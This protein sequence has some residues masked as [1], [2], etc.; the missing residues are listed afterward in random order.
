MV[1][2]IEISWIVAVFL[3]S[4]RLG[5][6]LLVTPILDGFAVPV[7]IKVFLIMAL[8]VFLV[9]CLRLSTGT[10]PLTVG[11][12]LAAG[13]TELVNGALLAFGVFTAFG[14]V[15]FAGKTLDIQMGF[16]VANVF[17][18]VTRSQSPL[19]G[20]ALGTLAVVMFFLTDAHHALMRGVAYSLTQV[21]LGGIV[22]NASPESIVRQFGTTFTL[23]LLFA[24][25]VVFCLFLLEI[26]LAVLSRNLPQ[27]NI[28]VISIPVKIVA[29]FLA[30]GF[31]SRHLES[32]FNKIFGSIFTFWDM[33]L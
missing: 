31:L 1:F 2:E 10:M 12:L 23:G 4:I 25:P 21:P 15:A 18:P 19:L 22:A 14:A 3:C 17:D 24:A 11:S 30:L 8:S 20:S 26:G 13:A 29:G 16:G 33:L 7:R 9:T 5:A 32:V 28:F 27:M 6:L